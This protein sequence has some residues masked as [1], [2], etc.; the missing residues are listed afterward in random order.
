MGYNDLKL[1]IRRFGASGSIS[2][3]VTSQDVNTNKSIVKLVFTVTRTSGSTHWNDAKT[4][5]FTCDGQ[6]S[7]SSLA[8]PTSKTSASCYKSF[9]ISHSADGTKSISYSARIA[10]G[11]SAGTVSASGSMTLPTIARYA[12]ITEYAVD[13]KTETT[14][15]HHIVVDAYCSDTYYKI[16]EV[17]ADGS[18]NYGPWISMGECGAGAR[19]TYT[20]T[21]LTANKMYVIG[22]KCKRGD[23]G[24]EK[25]AGGA[26]SDKTYNYPY[27]TS[28]P[29]FTIGNAYTIQLYNPLGRNCDVRIL[30]N[31]NVEMASASTRG[32]SITGFD[33]AT[34]IENYY[35]SIPNSQSST[36]KVRLI[37][38]ELGRDVR[39]TGGTYSVNASTNAPTFENFTYADTN[40]TTL[41]LTGDS[42]I[43]IPGYSDITATISSAN[44][45]VAKNDATMSS[46][47]FA[48]GDQSASAPYSESSDVNITIS[49]AIS[50]EFT[51]SAFDSRGISTPVTKTATTIVDYVKLVKDVSST[52]LRTGGVSE[53]TTLTLKG[54]VWNNSFGNVTN[55]IT[56][57]TYKYRVMGS[58]SEYTTG[59]TTITPTVDNDG[60]FTFTGIIQGD[61]GSGFDIANSYEVVVTVEDELSSIK[62][63]FT[64]PSGKPHIAYHK[65]GISIMGA[66]NP[67]NGG[68]LQI[69]GV[70]IE[71]LFSAGGSSLP[72]G[73]V[74]EFSG[75][76]I[77]NGWL[78]CDGRS[79]AK[80]D[81]SD[82]FDVIGYTYGGSGAN[83]NIPNLKGRVAV[84]YNSSESEFNS[85]GKTGGNKTHTHT[86]GSHALSF[87]ELPTRTMI[88]GYYGS[89][90]QVTGRVCSGVSGP[91][92]IETNNFDCYDLSG[93]SGVAHSHGDTGSGSS[94][95]PY[96][97][98]YYIIKAENIV[99]PPVQ[100][101]VKNDYST[102]TID[103]Y[104]C[105]YVNGKQDE[106]VSGTNI[107][108]VNGSSIL[109]SG[110]LT[111]VSGEW[112]NIT[113]TLSDQTDL[114]NA[115]DDKQDELVSGTNIKTINGASILGSGDI[116]VSTDDE[117]AIQTTTP[118]GN[119]TLWINPDESATYYGNS[120]SNTYGTSQTI[121]Y[122]QE[123]LNGKILWTNSSPNSVL[124]PQDITLNSSNYNYLE[125]YFKSFTDQNI[126]KSIK[127]E[128]GQNA[129]LD[130]SFFF[131][132][133]IFIGTRVIEYK[134]DTTL[135]VNSGRKIIQNAQ[136]INGEDNGWIIPTKIIGYK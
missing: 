88:Q 8:L 96:I 113:G 101:S 26:V 59:V 73:A 95:Q 52:L 124:A 76:S 18:Y 45:A 56:S 70:N 135:Y 62:Y 102:S 129:V 10:T 24:L 50:P 100:S 104:S 115:L 94:L 21:G 85:L 67:E 128:K 58:T 106:L 36:Y 41:A 116:S 90:S 105:N 31:S 53:E 123:Y 54:T 130:C 64:L 40:A 30:S 82:L 132:N 15:T 110:D 61:T 108:T 107:K 20:V 13:S 120:I 66:Y 60:N 2:C 6:T 19:K 97:T 11:T 103:V 80:A 126:M 92:W 12:N 79:L 91:N 84:G 99:Q 121:G 39:Y 28:A 9:E 86:T 63:T 109:G 111:I 78:V 118:S 133:T 98:I 69:D 43:F 131:N 14:I 77:P 127:V 72:I 44:K 3:T 136:I 22:W 55:S 4:V 29:N 23:S 81:Y 1:N 75:S 48:N 125:I 5:T 83:F 65:N 112:G 47:R 119:E 93:G 37:V 71:D 122:S 34:Q 42:Q 33:S 68:K 25:E 7:T 27:P 16:A 117:V 38:S 46:Y 114:K 17:Q 51:V 87:A 89:G 57:V 35:N 74:I 32:T 49:S 134:N